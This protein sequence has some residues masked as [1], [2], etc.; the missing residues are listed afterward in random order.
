MSKD[1]SFPWLPFSCLSVLQRWCQSQRG[2]VLTWWQR[3][4]RTQGL[5]TLSLPLAM[6]GSHLS[7]HLYFEH[8][9]KAGSISQHPWRETGERWMVPQQTW[10]HG[11]AL[12]SVLCFGKELVDLNP[13]ERRGTL[14]TGFPRAGLNASS[15]PST[16]TQLEWTLEPSCICSWALPGWAGGLS[17]AGTQRYLLSDISLWRAGDNLGAKPVL[18]LWN[19]ETFW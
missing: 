12:F 19:L 10:L 18:K 15:S 7:D 4:G 16:L 13:K 11:K 14:L 8:F 17:W 6:H 3:L 1:C 9:R 2:R 5:A